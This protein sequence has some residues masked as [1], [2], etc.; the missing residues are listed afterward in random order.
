MKH[1]KTAGKST[2]L[3]V[4]GALLLAAALVFV[5][6]NLWTDYKAGQTADANLAV[7]ADTIAEQEGSAATEEETA[8]L[9][10]S[11]EHTWET[12]PT[13][14]VDSYEYVGILSIPSL[15]R[16]LP[17]LNSWSYDLL[18]V[19]PCRYA[20]SVYANNM[21]IAAHNY[22][23]HFGTLKNLDVG[24]EVIFLDTAGNRFEYKV[25]SIE[26]LQSEQTEALVLGDWDLTL[27]TCTPGG[28]TRVTVRC[29][30][31]K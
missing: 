23:S 6:Y 2:I 15:G 8:S 9:E 21:I 19:S 13:V 14:A 4:L 16:E 31:E 20:G 26:T 3:T 27:F 11:S 12:M 24:A 18:K 7:L 1:K 17:V 30:R 25:T 5:V 28:E 29:T 10:S 22:R